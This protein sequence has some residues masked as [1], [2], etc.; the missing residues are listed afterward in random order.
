[1]GSLG[2]QRLSSKAIKNT[3]NPDWNQLF[4]FQNVQK[5]DQLV[6]SV[7]DKDHA[8]SDDSLGDGIIVVE[9]LPVGEEMFFLVPLVGGES[10]ENI[11]GVIDDKVQPVGQNIAAVSA[12]TA[13]G[14]QTGKIVGHVIQKIPKGKGDKN[15]GTVA[16]G[17][18]LTSPLG[19][20][21]PTA[22]SRSLPAHDEVSVVERETDLG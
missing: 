7:W 4:G 19:C 18:T 22:L 17:I 9:N 21:E 12:E 8:G 15:K 1:M 2:N 6:V 5:G 10:G 3:L 16:V 11:H 14:G 13:I 20:D